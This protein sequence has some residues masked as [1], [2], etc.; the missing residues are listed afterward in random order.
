VRTFFSTQ[1]CLSP[2]AF[3][4]FAPGGNQDVTEEEFKAGFQYLSELSEQEYHKSLSDCITK[5]PKDRKGYEWHLGSPFYSVG[6][7]IGVSVKEP[8]ATVEILAGRELFPPG[9]PSSHS[10][11]YRAWHLDT[12]TLEDPSRRE[13]WQYKT[14]EAICGELSE[15]GGNPTVLQLAE[16]ATHE[17]GFFGYLARSAARYICGDAELRKKINKSVAEAKTAGFNAKHLRPEVLVQAG[18]LALGSHL[19]T[20]I[21]VFAFVGAPV[22]AGFVLVLYS[23]GTDAY[24]SYVRDYIHDKTQ[25][26]LGGDDIDFS[27]G[28]LR[29]ERKPPWEQ[30]D[31]P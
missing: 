24:C 18:G 21:P 6:R 9:G 29:P 25:T 26:G 1:A 8:F 10:G 22:I 12:S 27:T 17:I 5:G 13:T 7:L 19:V 3:A 14:L 23:I 30:K 28:Q 11:S 2:F 20:H 16:Y 31:R 15:E 4:L